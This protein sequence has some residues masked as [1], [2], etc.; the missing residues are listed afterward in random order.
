MLVV[1]QY[2]YTY[3]RTKHARERHMHRVVQQTLSCKFIVTGPTSLYRNVPCKF[4]QCAYVTAEELKHMP[5]DVTL[6]D[7]VQP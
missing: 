3:V 1:L 6:A 7:A 5:A 4:A 2:V